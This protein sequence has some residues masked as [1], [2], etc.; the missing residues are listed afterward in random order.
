MGQ[1]IA[2]KLLVSQIK[3]V[4]CRKFAICIFINIKLTIIR[5]HPT[6]A[7]IRIKTI[8][9]QMKPLAFPQSFLPGR[10][11]QN[12]A[13]FVSDVSETKKTVL[14]YYSKPIIL[15]GI[16]EKKL[17]RPMNFPSCKR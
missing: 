14:S 13:E 10:R 5:H 2:R 7:I 4:Q 12:Y 9:D 17:V 6:P 8:C 15:A 16:D 11:V 3:F 1:H